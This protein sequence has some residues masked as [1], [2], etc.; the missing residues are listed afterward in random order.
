MSMLYK[1]ICAPITGSNHRNSP[2]IYHRIGDVAIL[3]VGP[4]N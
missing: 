3:S 2:Y 1:K 4:V